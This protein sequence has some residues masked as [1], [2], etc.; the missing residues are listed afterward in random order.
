MREGKRKKE[1]GQDGSLMSVHSRSMAELTSNTH[2]HTRYATIA[3]KLAANQQYDTLFF[4]LTWRETWVN[5]IDPKI[6]LTQLAADKKLLCSYVC[7]QLDQC[8]S[9]WQRENREAVRVC[10][11]G[12]R[13]PKNSSRGL[14]LACLSAVLIGCQSTRT[15]KVSSCIVDDCSKTP[16]GSFLLL[17]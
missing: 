3:C 12:I 2:A 16:W 4:F 13:T 1:R 17:F 7:T 8:F 10:L 6:N 14:P 9:L 5:I 15:D 11:K